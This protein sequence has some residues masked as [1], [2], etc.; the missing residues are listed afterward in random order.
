MNNILYYTVVPSISS[1]QNGTIV[2]VNVTNDITVTCTAS[3]VPAPTILFYFEGTLLDR[4]DGGAGIG[5]EI[6]MRVQIGDP[7]SPTMIS[8]STYEVSRNMTLFSTRD[9]P[10]TGFECTA[11]NSIIDMDL[12]LT[13][14][15]TVEFGFI[16]QGT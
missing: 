11:V 14:N 6:P 4:T 15:D 10:L 8:D 3:A 12:E 7:S 1:P 2:S 13:P 5:D 16:V 9:E